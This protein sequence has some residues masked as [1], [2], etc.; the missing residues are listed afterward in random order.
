VESEEPGHRPEAGNR[1]PTAPEVAHDHRTPRHAV[2]LAQHEV[3][4]VILEVVQ[5]LRARHDVDACRREGQPSRV[6][7]DARVEH[8]ARQGGERRRLVEAQRVEPDSFSR[9]QPPRP[10]GYVR[11]AG[12]HVEQRRGSG[13]QRKHPAHLGQ[14]RVGAPEDRVGAADVTERALTQRW[15]GVGIVEVFEPAAPRG[16]EQSAYRSSCA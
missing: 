10:Q 14:Y 1:E 6:A 11:K 7:A 9:R 13:E 5:H 16:G 12:A 15:G 2:H 3:D 8:L 4:L